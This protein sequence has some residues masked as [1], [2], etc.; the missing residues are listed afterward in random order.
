MFKAT[1]KTYAAKEALN[2]IGFKFNGE[3]KEWTAETYNTELYKKM[4]RP[5]YGRRNARLLEDVK[6]ECDRNATD[7][8]I[9]TVE[10]PVCNTTHEC[11]THG[12]YNCPE[13]G[14]LIGPNE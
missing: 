14:A 9:N 7:D 8:E 11:I 6:I 13:C 2:A 10:C 5:A 3:A 4:L 12:D 1:G